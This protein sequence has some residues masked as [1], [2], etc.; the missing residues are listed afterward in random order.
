MSRYIKLNERYERNN[1]I[2]E[3]KRKEIDSELKDLISDAED[4]YNECLDIYRDRLRI[5]NIFI[6]TVNPKKREK[7]EDDFYQVKTSFRFLLMYFDD[8]KL[9]NDPYSID[10]IRRYANDVLEHAK[11]MKRR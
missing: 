9:Y 4:A 6:N 3:N 1:R 10:D 2:S 5:K 7:V 11:E 8:F